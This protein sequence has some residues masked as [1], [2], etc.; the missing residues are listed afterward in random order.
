MKRQAALMLAMTWQQQQQQQQQL[1]MMMKVHR[2][3]LAGLAQCAPAGPL[4]LTLVD[5]K[6]LRSAQ[7]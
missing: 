4:E 5:P 1:T 2:P 6:C 3:L 7:S